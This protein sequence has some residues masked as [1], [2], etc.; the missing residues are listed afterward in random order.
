MGHNRKT[1][2]RLEW[3]QENRNLALEN[4]KAIRNLAQDIRLAKAKRDNEL[5]DMESRLLAQI[6]NVDNKLQGVR[7]A[8]EAHTRPLHR[9]ALD[10]IQA[11]GRRIRNVIQ[12]APSSASSPPAPARRTAPT[13]RRM[14]S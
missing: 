7:D 13:C 5:L 12:S 8:F 6:Q 9:K 1:A 14:P 2:K 3:I 4:Q 11:A 10:W